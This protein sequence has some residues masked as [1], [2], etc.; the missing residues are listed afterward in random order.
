V[1]QTKDCIFVDQQAY[2]Q[3]L[4]QIELSPERIQSKDEL[5]TDQEKSQL[6]SVSGQML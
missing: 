5:L 4:K 1:V 6:R 2:V 3:G